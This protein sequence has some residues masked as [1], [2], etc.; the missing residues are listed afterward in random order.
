MSY[1]YNRNIVRQSCNLPLRIVPCQMMHLALLLLL[2]L[3]Q[4]YVFYLAGNLP[5]PYSPKDISQQKP[6]HVTES[7][8]R[9]LAKWQQQA[10]HSQ[11]IHLTLISI[12]Q[13]INQSILYLEKCQNALQHV[14]Q[15]YVKILSTRLKC[16]HK[17]TILSLREAILQLELQPTGQKQEKQR[18]IIRPLFFNC[19]LGYSVT[20]RFIYFNSKR[21]QF[22]SCA[23]RFKYQTT[24][25]V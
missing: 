4:A 6:R 12:N 17:L 3:Y 24:I 14:K 18:N 7:W 2:S 20:L 16:E 9:K 8:N 19:S 13:S 21:S 11:S 15:M 23:H 25:E 1:S 5:R 10:I 22:H